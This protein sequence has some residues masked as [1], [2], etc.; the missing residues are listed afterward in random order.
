MP[1]RRAP[2]AANPKA[3]E[4]HYWKKPSKHD[5]SDNES[6]KSSEASA[7]SDD[8]G[9]EKIMVERYWK[10][11]PSA[12]KGCEAPSGE[13][14][15]I[16]SRLWKKKCETNILPIEKYSERTGGNGEN[17]RDKEMPSV[18]QSH[19]NRPYSTSAKSESSSSSSVSS[20]SSS[21]SSASSSESE[22]SASEDSS[23]SDG[24]FIEHYWTRKTRV[25]PRSRH[26]EPKGKR[27]HGKDSPNLTRDT[28][29]NTNLLFLQ[30]I[31]RSCR[32]QTR[33]TLSST[34][35]LSEM[36]ILQIPSQ[37]LADII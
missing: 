16:I 6:T 30:H 5:V 3:R 2:R 37:T 9:E 29:T 12:H 27:S 10:R 7:A 28:P 18:N 8:D 23:E 14:K 17:G 36:R 32:P 1:S 26:A 31:C 11:E 4:E 19:F 20:E 34:T 21:S 35:S 25:R 15:I 22:N 13:E 33:I 24:E